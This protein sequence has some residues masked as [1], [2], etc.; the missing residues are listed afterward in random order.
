MGEPKRYIRALDCERVCESLWME[1]SVGEYINEIKIGVRVETCDVSV[2]GFV[3]CEGLEKKVKELM[4]GEKGK[5]VRKKVAEL[6][7]SAMKAVEEGGPSWR[8]LN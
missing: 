4:V 3:K 8:C 7:N 5:E 1:L 6:R 2:N